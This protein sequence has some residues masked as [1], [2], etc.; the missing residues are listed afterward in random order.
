MSLDSLVSGLCRTRIG[1]TCVDE[2]RSPEAGGGEWESNP[3]AAVR[4]HAGFE[5]QEHHRTP[6]PSGEKP[7]DWNKIYRSYG[8]MNSVLWRPHEAKDLR[9]FRFRFQRHK[10]NFDALFQGRRYPPEHA[11]RMAFIV[12]VFKP[13]DNRS[14]CVNHFGQLVSIV[15]ENGSL[16]IMPGMVNHDRGRR[17]PGFLPG[18]PP[19]M[20]GLMQ[21]SRAVATRFNRDWNA[22]RAK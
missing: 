8:E 20:S 15:K 7:N 9:R 1:K 14:S 10:P 11:Q 17:L 21:F 3:P 18:E 16:A 5:D 2:I 19:K 22:G 6:R 13:A 4:R 12:G